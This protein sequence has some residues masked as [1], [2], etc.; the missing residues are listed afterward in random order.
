[1][2]KNFVWGTLNNKIIKIIFL[3]GGLQ[4]PEG[5]FQEGPYKIFKNELYEKKR[6]GLQ[7]KVWN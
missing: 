1:M 3:R 5:G 4:S 7:A 6:L 2:I